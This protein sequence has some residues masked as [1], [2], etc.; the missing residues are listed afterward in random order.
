MVFV[1]YEDAQMKYK[2][3]Y[4][5]NPLSFQNMSTKCARNE[6]GKNVFMEYVVGDFTQNSVFCDVYIL[7]RKGYCCCL[8]LF[9]YFYPLKVQAHCT[10]HN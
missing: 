6:C 5:F 3:M 10:G 4:F 8:C 2:V 9:L 7:Y 1:G